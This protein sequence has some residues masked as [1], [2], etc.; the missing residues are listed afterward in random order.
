MSNPLPSKV[1]QFREHYREKYQPKNYSG[2][3]HF[4]SSMGFA[5]S[6]FIIALS[7][8]SDVSVYEWLTI[9]ITFIYAN[10][11]EYLVHRFPMHRPFKRIKV[12]FRRHARQHHR[13]FTDKAMQFDSSN[14]FAVVLFPP[15]LII[16]FLF[17]FA[18]PIGLILAFLA[19]A[20]VAY[21]FA[22]TAFAYF[23]N[24]EIFHTVYHLPN[25]HWVYRSKL[26]RSLRELHLH[27]HNQKLMSHYNFNITYPI[28]DWLF[29][30]YYREKGSKVKVQNELVDN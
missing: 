1:K 10:F 11:V 20:N 30:T 5:V 25:D 7:Q 6:V 27:H 13:F 9:P 29:G 14:D 18:L 8:L 28:S 21:L 23:I 2:V 22:V 24:Y 3:V 17:F 19:S 15:Y 16:F 12:L 26:M 4:C